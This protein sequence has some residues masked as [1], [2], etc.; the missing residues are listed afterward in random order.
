MKKLP[1]FKRPFGARRVIEIGGGHDPY[2]GITHAVDKFPDDNSQRAGSMIV[3]QG[4]VFK[5]GELE[6]IPFD[7]D[8]EFDYLI[9]SHVMEHVSSAEKAVAEINRVSSRGYLETPS[10]L[11]EQLACPIPF[12]PGKDFHTLF[13]WAGAKRNSLR[14]IRKSSEALGKFCA[15]S[16]GNLARFFFRLV[17]E[18]GIDLEPLLSRAAKTTRL[19][20]DGK[21]ELKEYESF[22][23][24][25]RAGDCAY[26]SAGSIRRWMHPFPKPARFGKLRGILREY[27]FL[28][29]RGILAAFS[30][31]EL[32]QILV[33]AQETALVLFYTHWSGGSK[34]QRRAFGEAAA[35]SRGGAV[36]VEVDAE[37]C[38]AASLEFQIKSVPSTVVIAPGRTTRVLAGNQP[39]SVLSAAIS[40][41]GR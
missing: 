5:E 20:F 41:N 14:V 37:K 34:A 40:A 31:Q 11:R 24:A 23:A 2:R 21:L 12:E 26:G 35:R 3:G 1:F 13:C 22:E 28:A 7:G 27:D 38:P 6:S 30:E 15:C 9:A 17:R 29:N 8:P 25:C 16:N 33:T 39:T 32:K 18:E 10:P 4:A 19:Y 36:F